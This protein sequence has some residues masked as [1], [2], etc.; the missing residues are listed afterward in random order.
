MFLR[1]YWYADPIAEIARRFRCGESRVKM[2]LSRTRG[3][4]KAFLEKEEIHL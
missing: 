2:S 3:E 1:R 4:L